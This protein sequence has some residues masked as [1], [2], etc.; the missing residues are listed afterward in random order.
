MKAIGIK[1][2]CA[3][4]SLLVGLGGMSSAQADVDN[5]TLAAAANLT[6]VFGMSCP[7]GTANVQAFV[8]D[9]GNADGITVNVGIVDP[10]G[11]ASGRATAPDGGGVSATVG[12][13][14]AGGG[15]YLI[16]V[17]KPQAGAQAYAVNYECIAGGVGYG[18]DSSAISQDQ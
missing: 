4:T 9:A 5:E 17:H 10:Q 18:P 12:L 15:N 3:T 7:L 2:L 1:K 6:D 16:L 11:G 13:A 8:N 14:G